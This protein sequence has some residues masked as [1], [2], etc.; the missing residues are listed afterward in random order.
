[1]NLIPGVD[2]SEESAVLEQVAYQT[3]LYLPLQ[4]WESED[5]TS[6]GSIISFANKNYA[7][8]GDETQT[9]IDTLNEICDQHPEFKSAELK[10][11][12]WD[13]EAQFPPEGF[14]ACVFQ[15][16]DE[17]SVC[18]R[19]TPEGAWVD[20]GKGMTGVVD[21]EYLEKYV[22]DGVEVSVSPMQLCAIEYMQAVIDSNNDGLPISISGHSKGG[23]EA[24]LAAVIFG[25]YVDAAYSFD[26]QGFPPEVVEQMKKIPGWDEAI[27]KILGIH[28]DNDFVHGLGEQIIPSDNTL[29]LQTPNTSEE[30]GDFIK[31]HFITAIVQDG[32]LTSR[33]FEG[34]ISRSVKAISEAIMEIDDLEQREAICF[35]IMNMLQDFYGSPPI[36]GEVEGTTFEDSKNTLIEKNFWNVAQEILKMI[37]W[38]QLPKLPGQRLIEGLSALGKLY[39]ILN[40]E[41]LVDYLAWIDEPDPDAADKFLAEHEFENEQQIIDY[42][43][44]HTENGKLEYLVRGALLRCRHGSHA[45]RLNLLKCHGIYITTHPAIHEANCVAGLGPEKD[46]ITFFGVCKAP[47]PPASESVT[48]KKDSPRDERGCPCGDAPF[49]VESGHKCQPEIVG[50]WKDTYP[51][52]RIVDNGLL[53]PGDRALAE[54]DNP[55][56]MPHGLSSVTTL[57]FLVCRYGGLIEPYN[58]GQE[59][60]NADE[61]AY[62]KEHSLEDTAEGQSL[63]EVTD[64]GV[65]GE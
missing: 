34:P 19:G 35:L 46:N 3:A 55:D 64:S 59:Y 5:L 63:S 21:A 33:G 57:S 53:D 6:L 8:F 18:Y 10:N 41:N 60:I 44:E 24:Q 51:K 14:R 65:S 9:Y 2:T 48:Y 17:L 50:Y 27:N 32:N 39:G 52:T 12:S 4:D 62:A 23:N 37:A 58:S 54:S 28:A 30:L 61:E 11:A 25:E 22:C 40:A 16:G 1:M 13:N 31:N 38:N 43:K 42:L 45:R 29:Y 26:G 7:Q 47:T 49:G 56:T 15:R 20:N 36:G